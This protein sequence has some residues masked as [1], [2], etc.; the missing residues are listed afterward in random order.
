MLAAALRLA[1]R[2]VPVFPCAQDKAPLTKHGFKDAVVDA[3]TIKSWWRRWR[4]ALVGVPSGLRFVVV[5]VDLQHASAAHWFAH[6]NLPT[7]RVHHTRSGGCHLLFQPHEAV[8]CTQGRIWRHV[9]TKG[10]VG[11]S[12]AGYVV[13]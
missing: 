10:G 2:G 12:A 11:G 9:D 8:G 6:A 13:W 5:D 4:E 1:A 3:S 7:T